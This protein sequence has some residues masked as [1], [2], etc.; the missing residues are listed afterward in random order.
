MRMRDSGFDC[1]SARLATES[2]RIS[3]WSMKDNPLLVYV[4]KG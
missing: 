4:A 1:R 2:R 3:I